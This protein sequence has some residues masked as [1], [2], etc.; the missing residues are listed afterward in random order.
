MVKEVKEK[1]ISLGYIDS[2]FR[3]IFRKDS[4]QFYLYN[5]NN[6]WFASVDIGRQVHEERIEIENVIP[7][8]IKFEDIQSYNIFVLKNYSEKAKKFYD[9][10]HPSLIDKGFTFKDIGLI[11]IIFD[12]VRLGFSYIK[13]D[14]ELFF[15]YSYELDTLIA[16]GYEEKIEIKDEESLNKYIN[17]AMIWKK[18]RKLKETIYYECEKGDKLDSSLL[19]DIPIE[20]YDEIINLMANKNLILS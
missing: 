14:L 1:L 13:K 4:I 10:I 9:S 6:K 3:S 11:N 15:D 20:Y 2:C 8:A 16:H 5:E 12:R 18:V 17:S 7:M 19:K